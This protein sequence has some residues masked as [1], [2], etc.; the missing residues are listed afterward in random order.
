VTIVRHLTPALR[1]LVGGLL[2]ALT[3]TSV[4]VAV[5]QRIVPLTGR[6]TLVVAG[7]SMAP[8][9]QV[10]SAI[11][12][13]PVDP[14]ALAVG[15][16]VSLKSGPAKAI[17]THRIIRLIQ[18]DGGLWL[19]TKGDANP[20]PD[21]SILP[22]SDVMGRVVA[23]VPYVGYMVVLASSPSGLILIVSLGLVLLMAGGL[24]NPKRPADLTRSAA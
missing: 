23:A 19:E 10:G 13:E 2:I 16:V 18:R 6:T 24:L 12:V 7:P 5:L 1:R 22:A 8:A 14:A 20:A 4:G 15:D 17:F 11:V 3:I 9:F 21:P